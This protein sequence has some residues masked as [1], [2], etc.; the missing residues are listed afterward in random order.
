M[1]HLEL[2]YSDE[3]DNIDKYFSHTSW[4]FQPTLIPVNW[5]RVSPIE[6]AASWT[7]TDANMK[8]EATAL[9]TSNEIPIK[10]NFSSISPRLG[11]PQEEYKQTSDFPF[12]EICNGLGYPF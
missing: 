4:E 8:W 2:E 1:L 12:W 11:L 6:M 9:M 3:K 5:D 7:V 10:I